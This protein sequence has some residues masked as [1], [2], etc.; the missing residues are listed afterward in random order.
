MFRI[1]VEGYLSQPICE[2][3]L[4]DRYTEIP[5]LF[6]QDNGTTYPMLQ[7]LTERFLGMSAGS[8]PVECL[9]SITGLICNGR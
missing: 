2:K 1:E 4:L 8:V 5:L 9:F 7:Q 6:W 3:R